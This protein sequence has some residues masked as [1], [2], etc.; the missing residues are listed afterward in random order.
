MIC[1]IFIFTFHII[2]VLMKNVIIT[3]FFLISFSI[4]SQKKEL[5]FTKDSDTVYWMKYNTD[6]NKMFDLQPIQENKNEI[7]FRIKNHCSQ[8]EIS[9]SKDSVF[10]KIEFYV[11]EFDQFKDS[12]TTFKKQYILNSVTV[13]QIFHEIDSLKINSIPSDNLI[14]NWQQGFDGTTYIIEYKNKEQYSFKH[15]WT[16]EVQTNI[17][18]AIILESFL[19]RV[20]A[21][22][23]VEKINQLFNKEI[24]F[25]SWM[26]YGS[27]SVATR[28]M[29]AQEYKEYKKKKRQFERKNKT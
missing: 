25:R 7:V 26:C 10:G 14:P 17:N 16:P 15:Y 29:T 4:Y 5:S 21:I 28:I 6:V 3:L 13:N 18:E 9:K 22:T 19:N 27:A 2:K 20:Y 12:T 23:D 8:I 1:Q 11:K 24:P